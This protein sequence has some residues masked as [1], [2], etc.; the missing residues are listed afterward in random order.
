[1]EITLMMFVTGGYIIFVCLCWV[2]WVNKKIKSIK[3]DINKLEKDV[4][5]INMWL[6]KTLRS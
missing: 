2:F 6:D 1:M 4:V 3:T 5:R